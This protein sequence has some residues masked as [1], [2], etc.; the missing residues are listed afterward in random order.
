MTDVQTSGLEGWQFRRIASG[1]FGDPLNAFAH[2]MAWYQDSI[3]VGTTRANLCLLKSRLPLHLKSWP[4]KC[5]DDVYKLDL[6]AQ[7]W[8]YSTASGQWRMVHQ[9]PLIRG[10]NGQMV[11]RE[12]GFRAMAVLQAPS[13]PI[14]ALYVITWAPSRALGPVILRSYDGYRFQPVTGYSFG[15]S[16]ATTYRTL[17]QFKGQI[18]TSPTGRQGGKPN[19]PENPIVLTTRDPAREGWLPA[20]SPG[21]GDPNNLTIFEMIIYSGHLYAG[22]LN[23][24][25]GFQIWKT[26]AVGS[27]PYRWMPVIRD[28]AFRGSLN[29]GVLSMVVFRGDL[30]VGSCIQNGGYD[31]TYN[32]GPAPPEIIRIHPDDSWDLIVGEPRSTPVGPRYPLSGF[33]PGFGNV[34]NGYFWRF[35]EFEGSLYVGTLD[36]SVMLP[37]VVTEETSFPGRIVELLGRENLMSFNAGFDMFRSSDGINWAPVT[38]NGFGNPYNFGLRTLVGTPYGLFAGTANPFG[39]EIAVRTAMG[40]DYVSNP[41]G[42]AE[43]WVGSETLPKL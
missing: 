32:V 11:P 1:G 9:A 22:T 20:S 40:W 3:F 2:T 41:D 10:H 38:T 21:F 13:D 25:K 18:F 31:V 33:G 8:R 14:P 4:V 24:A 34:F 15:G 26:D 23:A 17:V 19:T 36:L 6:R 28:G 16:K 29:E 5:P 43:V 35:A 7:I 30:F 39:P 27:P 37:Y 42:G 12:I